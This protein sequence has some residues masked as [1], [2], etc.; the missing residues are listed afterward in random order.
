MV[1]SR[2]H[3]AVLDRAS[4]VGRPTSIGPSF[5]FNNDGSLPAGN[6]PLGNGGGDAG[7][8]V[9]IPAMYLVV[10]IN[11]QFAFGLGINVP[12]G[13]E[14]EW[15]D[16]WIG[17]YQGLH[18]KVETININ[19][20][21]SWKI[22]DQFTLGVGAN[23]QRAKLKFTSAQNYGGA[24]AAQLCRERGV[25]AVRWRQLRRRRTGSMPT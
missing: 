14:T 4:C 13:L 22:N 17:R 5:K 16:G 1:E 3:V 11:Q 6:Q 21:L 12:F 10:P 25:P 8:L 24:V 7:N 23:W 19:P 20:A 2:G 18:S 15:D 9:C